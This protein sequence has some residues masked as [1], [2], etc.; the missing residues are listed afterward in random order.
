ME[1]PGEQVCFQI[2]PQLQRQPFCLLPIVPLFLVIFP[3]SGGVKVRG[4]SGG[5]HGL[6]GSLK[7]IGEGTGPGAIFT[8]QC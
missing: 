1:V 4:W 3:P 7:V 2:L 5:L 8:R 6:Q